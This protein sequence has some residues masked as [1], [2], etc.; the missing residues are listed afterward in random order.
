MVGTGAGGDRSAAA[1]RPNR[2]RRRAGAVRGPRGREIDPARRH[3]ARYP[4]PHWCSARRGSSRRRR[5]RSAALHRLLRPV[6]RFTD[7]LPAP[8]QHALQAFGQEAGGNSDQLPG[9]LGALSLLAGAAGG[10][11][12]AGGDRRRH[13]LDE[14]SAAALL[15]IHR[16]VQMEP[17]AMLFAARD[18]DA[19]TFDSG[20]LPRLR[21]KGLDLGAVTTLLAEQSQGE[22]ST[23]VS[24][25]LLASTGGN[26]LALIELPEVLTAEQ[27]GARCRCPDGS[28]SQ[29]ASS[30]C[31]WNAPAGFPCRC[32]AG[33]ARGRRRRL[34]P[35]RHRAACARG[36]TAGVD[37]GGA[38]GSSPWTTSTCCGTHWSALRCTAPPPAPS[39]GRY[40]ALAQ[41]LTRADDIDRRAWHRSAATVEP[42][43]SVVAELADAA[44]GPAARWP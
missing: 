31:S 16:R 20:D 14:A 21:L 17:V 18:S 33:V 38:P 8:Q 10:T 43:E 24:A 44:P 30:G 12:G 4:Q 9:V 41:V 3:R 39:A 22:V 34:H 36:S 28:P 26:P 1:G 35:G 37:R 42:D 7:A 32:A 27:H 40:A 15:F 23:E 19:R 11:A 29:K 25:H 6:L 13:W 2:C 5:W